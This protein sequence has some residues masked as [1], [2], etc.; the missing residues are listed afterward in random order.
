MQIKHSTHP[1]DIATLDAGQ[2]RDRFLVED[3]DGVDLQVLR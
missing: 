3:M 1:Q 2:L